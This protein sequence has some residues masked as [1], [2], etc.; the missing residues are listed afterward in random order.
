MKN[1]SSSTGVGFGT[2]LFL[3]FLTLKLTGVIDWSWWWI[4]APLWAGIAIFFAVLAV[5]GVLGGVIALIN[6]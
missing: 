4:T 2:V 1:Q 3:I 6:R 5:I